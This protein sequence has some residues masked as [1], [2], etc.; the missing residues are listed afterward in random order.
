[1]LRVIDV[2][3]PAVD[4]LDQLIRPTI[5]AGYSR[6][7]HA[8][9]PRPY[10]DHGVLRIHTAV[11]GTLARAAGFA[12]SEPPA[13][14]HR[15]A[16]GPGGAGLSARLHSDHLRNHGNSI[17]TAGNGNGGAQRQRETANPP[18]MRTRTVLQRL[19]TG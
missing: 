17:N 2:P 10:L 12:R 9:D 3:D 7:D 15:A 11:S 14:G 19:G 4:G 6:N 1:M 13:R 18:D 16:R 8:G 5:D